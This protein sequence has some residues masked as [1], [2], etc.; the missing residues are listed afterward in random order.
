MKIF[1]Y[2]IS[3]NYRATVNCVN[4]TERSFQQSYKHIMWSDLGKS[5]WSW[6]CDIC[7]FL[8]NWS[9]HLEGYILLKTTWIG[10]VVPKLRAIAGLSKQQNTKE[11]HSIFWLYLAINAP[12]FW[13]PLDCN[14]HINFYKFNCTEWMCKQTNSSYAWQMKLGVLHTHCNL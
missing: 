12:D 5:V 13:I 10:P 3:P 1:Q 14:T 8:F 2:R 9:A 7:S 11:I 4:T 6:I